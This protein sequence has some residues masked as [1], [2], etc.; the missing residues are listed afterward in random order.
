MQPENVPF[1]RIQGVKDA[2][3]DRMQAVSV[4]GIFVCLLR[5]PLIRSCRLVE[6]R[7]RHVVYAQELRFGGLGKQ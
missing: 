5:G 6:L 3:H 1:P 4:A 2:M 7:L